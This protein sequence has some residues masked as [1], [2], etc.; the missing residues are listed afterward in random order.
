MLPVISRTR[1]RVGVRLE[2]HGL[3]GCVQHHGAALSN[4]RMIGTCGDKV[5]ENRRFDSLP[6]PGSR[7]RREYRHPCDSLRTPRR[8]A[9][10]TE[11]T[12]EP[13]QAQK[14]VCRTATKQNSLCQRLRL[15]GR[16]HR[17]SVAQ[18]RCRKIM[19]IGSARRGRSNLQQEP[20]GLL[21]RTRWPH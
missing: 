2:L 18:Q 7:P 15:N 6:R 11:E 4:N 13:G 20:V 5:I 17:A 19:A 21:N 10:R 16:A 1:R 14:L 3:V 12:M 8:V 9:V